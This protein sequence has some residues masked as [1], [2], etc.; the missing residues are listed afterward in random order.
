MILRTI[1]LATP[2]LRLRRFCNDDYIRAYDNWMSDPDVT[3]FLSWDTHPDREHSREVIDAWISEYGCGS[4]DWCIA[5]PD[6]DEPIGSITAVRDH[7]D[8]GWCELGYCLSQRYWDMGLMS[9]ALR[10]ITR[11]IFDYTDYDWIQARF[12]TENEASGRCLEK[13]NYRVAGE[14]VLPDPKTGR[15]RTYRF[16]VI[17][18]EDVFLL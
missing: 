5:L 17:R 11:F 4:M 10:A 18:R 12:D 9:E 7:P 8:E 6:T 3:H 2:R 1:E 14:R 13:C 15:Q 16:M